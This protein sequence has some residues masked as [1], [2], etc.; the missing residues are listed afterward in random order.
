M[1]TIATYAADP[2]GDN[3]P[4]MVNL[5][6]SLP[7]PRFETLAESEAHHQAVAAILFDALINSLPGGTFDRLLGLMHAKKASLFRVP[8]SSGIVERIE[9]LERTVGEHDRVLE[10]IYFRD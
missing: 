6:I 3:E 7:L 4:E 9:H 10:N 2:I 5:I 1:K 8:L